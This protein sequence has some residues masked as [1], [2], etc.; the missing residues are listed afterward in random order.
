MREYRDHI[1]K[2]LVANADIRTKEKVL[3]VV[4]GARVIGL[5]VPRLR[6]LVAEFRRDHLD[7]TFDSACELMDELCHDRWREEILFGIFLVGGFGKKV[8][9]VAWERLESWTDAL[10]NWETCDQL[11]SNVSGGVVAGNLDLVD[12]LVALRRSDNPWKR[13]FVL[14]TALELNHKGRAHPAETLRVCELFLADE[15]P[16]V[17]KALGWALKEASKNAATDVFEF[18]LTHR[19]HLPRSVLRDAA[20]KLTSAQKKHLGVD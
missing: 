7:L 4:P 8:A 15:E 20:K 14:A 1:H 9:G 5:S 19:Q 3:R 13:R 11:A 18:L 17:R 6:A 16:T 2:S 10:D 12:R